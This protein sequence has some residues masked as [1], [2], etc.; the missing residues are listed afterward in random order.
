MNYWVKKKQM[1]IVPE[2]CAHGFQTLEENTEAL[3]LV[4]KDYDPKLEKGIRWND[5]NFRIKWPLEVSEI[6]KKDK[7]WPNFI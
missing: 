4:S 2:G 7:N 1:I 6:S 5:K 3:Y